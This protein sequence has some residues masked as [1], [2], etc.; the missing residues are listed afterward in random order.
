MEVTEP[1]VNWAG[2]LAYK[3]DRV[4]A[5]ESVAEAQ[6]IVRSSGR[7]RVVGSRHCFNDIADTNGTHVSLERMNRVLS[8]DKARGSVTVEGGIR[9]GELGPYLHGQGCA[10]HNLASL[11]HISVAGA[12]A[13]AT[14]GSGGHG[15]LAT[16]VVELEFIDGKGDQITLSRERNRD[17]FEGA[18]VNLGAL[19]IV[20]KLT[21]E[22]QPTFDIRQDVFCGL[23]FA[24]LESHF[25]DIMRSGY[26]VSL[27]TTWQSDMVEQAWVKS[28]AKSDQ[29][30]AAADSFFEARPATRN[31]HPI[32]LDAINCTV[33]M[34][35]PGPAYD[36]LPHFRMGFT[37]A[38]GDEL[39]VEYFVPME[40]AIPAIRALRVQGPTMRDLLLVGEIRTIG[41]DDLWLSPCYRTPCVAFHFSF[42]QDWP[43]LK[44]IL[45]RLEAALSPMNPRPHWGKMFTMSAQNIQARYPRIADFRELRKRHDP[46]DKFCNA[47]VERYLL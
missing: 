27:F 40:H 28:V 30:F 37:P 17:I 32:D 16:A 7:V 35:V 29:R 11:P 20:S 39:Q 42:K 14:H 44:A 6:E 24:A 41:P 45:P 2:N 46:D 33:Q 4:L 25:E 26:S 22:I 3:A 23:P 47:F 13:T 21:L 43:R 34:G 36:R 18:I 38:S 15:N 5:P 31:M 10:L 19:G 8:L 12:C 9:Y 1:R